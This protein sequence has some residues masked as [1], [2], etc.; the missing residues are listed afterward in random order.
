MKNQEPGRALG[1][2]ETNQDEM[3]E[4]LRKLRRHL[5]AAAVVTWWESAHDGEP[6]LPAELVAQYAAL[7][8]EER[9]EIIGTIALKELTAWAEALLKEKRP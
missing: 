5:I 4:E 6:P 3:P 8:R 9:G 7:S 2:G 1:H